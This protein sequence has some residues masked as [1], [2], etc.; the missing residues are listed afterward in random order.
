DEITDLLSRGSGGEG[1][2]RPPPMAVELV[3]G[4]SLDEEHDRYRGYYVFASPFDKGS[5]FVGATVWS[6]ADDGET[7]TERG[8]VG[9]SKIAYVQGAD[10]AA[11]TDGGATKLDTASTVDL[12]PIGPAVYESVAAPPIDGPTSTI[13]ALTNKAIIGDEVVTYSTATYNDDG[14]YSISDIYRAQLGTSLSAH[15]AGTR[16]VALE[17]NVGLWVPIDVDEWDTEHQIRVVPYGLTVDDVQSVTLSVGR[18]PDHFISELYNVANVTVNDNA[19][20]L[21][22]NWSQIDSPYL[23]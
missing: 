19:T 9:P 15:A 2:Y 5:R 13:P 17:P 22:L 3:S 23:L 14:S 6:S 21:I 4:I 10:I 16:F 11:V 8:T 18:E 1:D 12:T 20:A 7:W